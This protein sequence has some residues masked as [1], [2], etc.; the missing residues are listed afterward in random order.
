MSTKP[1]R[2]ELWMA[3]LEPITGHEQG[4]KR[5]CLVFSDNLFNHG[6]AELVVVLPVT[7]KNRGIPLRVPVEPPE[8]GLKMTSYVMPEMIR[9]ISVRRLVRRLGKISDGTLR[10]VEEHVC[11]VLGLG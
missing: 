10:T 6:P 5:P 2:G 4:G 3:D 11:V 1:C 8:G 7:S 9:S